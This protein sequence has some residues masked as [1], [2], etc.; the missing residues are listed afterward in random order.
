MRSLVFFLIACLASAQPNTL[1]DVERASGWVLL[2]DGTEAGWR[3]MT[4]DS[5]P[6]E[7]W[8]IENGA[9]KTKADRANPGID[10]VT[11]GRFERFE[12]AFDWRLASGSNSGI[13]YLIQDY[14]L[15]KQFN[16]AMV[17]GPKALGFEF[18]LVDNERDDFA[19]DHP[20]QRAG[21]LYYYIAPGQNA[22]KPV[23]EW[24]TGRLV[25]DKGR[26]EHWINSLKVVEYDPD[27][28]QLSAAILAALIDRKVP[29]LTLQSARVLYRRRRAETAISLQHHSSEV[30]FRSLKIRKLP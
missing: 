3:S 1:S 18:Q 30:W 27:S 12:L 24:N 16:S 14:R 19:P 23:G 21:A 10:L 20:D 9:L 17:F 26:V 2:F 8:V 13:K 6:S 4:G 11:A 22:A 7:S 28:P 25:V 15:E 29:G 5:F